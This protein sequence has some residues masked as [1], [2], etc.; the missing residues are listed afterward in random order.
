MRGVDKCTLVLLPGF[1]G[2]GSLFARLCGELTGEIDPLVISY[3]NEARIGY[4]ELHKIIKPQLPTTPYVLLGESFGG[5]LAFL[6][7]ENHDVHLKGIILSASFIKNPRPGVARIVR[8]ILRPNHFRAGLTPAWYI[9][10]L[11]LN[12]V[13]DAEMTQ[14]I[15]RATCD[16]S[17]EVYYAR[18]REIADVDV[19]SIVRRCDLPVL[20]MRARWDRVVKPNAL[21]DIHSLT[22]T[23]QSI[24]FDAPHMLLQTRPRQAAAC[25][26]RFIT[27]VCG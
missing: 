7:A 2:T 9:N 21:Q 12:G 16:L 6:L 18:L 13:H 22:S 15:Q 25:I 10:C 19:S 8:P 4:R 3:P 24:T 23:L 11:L 20:Y 17:P 26:A 14:A 5:P 1:D 27:Q